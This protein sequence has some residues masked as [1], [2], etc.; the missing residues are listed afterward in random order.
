MLLKSTP[1]A[2]LLASLLFSTIASGS[3][4]VKGVHRTFYSFPDNDPPGPATAYDCGYGRGYTAGGTGTYDDPLTFATAPGE[5]KKCE[6]VWDPYVKKYLIHQDYCAQCV[7][8]YD[9]GIKHIDLWNGSPTH[10]A[11][12]IVRK[13]DRALTP[14]EP[15]PVV[16]KPSMDLDADSHPLF[17]DGVCYT[18]RVYPQ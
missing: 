4:V 10:N 3:K 14:D 5:F 7:I 9:D 6:I 8:D 16:R 17:E 2:A 12:K 11:H 13:C 18:E 1:I 15:Q